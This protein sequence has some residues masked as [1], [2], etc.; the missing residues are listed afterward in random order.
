MLLGAGHDAFNL[1]RRR[2]A[3]APGSAKRRLSHRIQ[4]S[5]AIGTAI[6]LAAFMA[7]VAGAGACG[8]AASPSAPADAASASAPDVVALAA[9]CDAKIASGDGATPYAATDFCALYASVCGGQSFAGML[10]PANC[11]A[12]YEGWA[13]MTID[14]TD[15]VQSCAS[16]HLCNAMLGSPEMHCTHAAAEGPC[17][18]VP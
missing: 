2:Q 11:V 16:S 17:M 5:G 6:T 12:T 18:P 9:M 13:T 10:T 4:R 15:G 7:L 3:D 1:P 14:G 8:G